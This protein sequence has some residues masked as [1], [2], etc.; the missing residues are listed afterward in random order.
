MAI[1]AQLVDSFTPEQVESFHRDGFLIIEEGL[2]A[3]DAL[4]PLRERYLRLFEGDY[5]TGIR[6]DEVNWVPG[7]DPEDRTR[8]LCNAWKSDTLVAAQ[9]LSE[10]IGRLAAQLAGYRGVRILQDNVL[11]KPPGTKAIGFHQDSSYADYLVPAEM[12]TCWMSLHD[13]EPDA[14]PLAFV[15]GSHRWPK[16]PP[17]RSQFHA[18]D[19]W[20]AGVRSSAPEGAEIETVPVVVKAGGGS[21]HHGLVWHGSE[22]NTSG[23]TARMAL[24]SHMIPVEARF[25]HENVDVT[26]SRYRRRGDLALDESFFPVMWDESGYRTPWLAELPPLP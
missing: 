3:P 16:T 2:I 19:D 6:P 25:H 22:P 4:E 21:F 11:W 17:E 15:P 23:T 7:R 8:Q 9:V 24:V 10:R 12:I 20:L 13:T 26:Y 5:E 18:P 14:G 1:S